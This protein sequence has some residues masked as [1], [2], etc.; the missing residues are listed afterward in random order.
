[1]FSTTPTTRCLVCTAIALARSATSAAAACGVVTTRIS[2][3]GQ[4]SQGERH[5]AGARGQVEEQDVEVAPEDV[6]EE[7]LHRAVQHRAAP[8][9]R[10]PGT[11]MP[12]E[13]TFTSW[14]TGEGSCRRPASAGWSRRASAAS[15]SRRRRRRARRP[16]ALDRQSAAARF[17]VT[18]D[19]PTLPLPDAIA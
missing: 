15:R 1:M 16:V 19:L 8:D 7:L 17:A 14:A 5:I 13:M 11:N 6:G 4:L 2:G 10:L 3:W 18:E 12:M 9:D